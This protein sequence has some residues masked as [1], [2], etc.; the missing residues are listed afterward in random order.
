MASTNDTARSC[1]LDTEPVEAVRG[2]IAVL[3]SGGASQDSLNGRSLPHCRHD[4]LA[5]R[6]RVT[7]LRQAWWRG[8]PADNALDASRLSST[9]SAPS[10]IVARDRPA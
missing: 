9:V 4:V 3:G 6:A 5:L 7:N 2:R 10:L 1:A 8:G